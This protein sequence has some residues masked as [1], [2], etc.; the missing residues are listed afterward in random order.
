MGSRSPFTT[1]YVPS[2]EQ[3]TH[4]DAVRVATTA[5]VT[6]SGLQTLDGA[7]GAANDRV[8]V[9]NQTAAA[10]NGIYL[11]KSGAWARTEDFNE[12]TDVKDGVQV[13]VNEGSTQAN[14]EWALDTPG[15]IDVGTTALTFVKTSAAAL[16][17][18]GGGLTKTGDT[19][20]VVAGNG[21]QV[22]ADSVEVLY[23]VVNDHAYGDAAANGVATTLARSDHNHG[24]PSTIAGALAD[25]GLLKFK[26]VGKAFDSLIINA[27]GKLE[28]GSGDA[29]VDVN[30]FR[31]A[32]NVLATADAFRITG[33]SAGTVVLTLKAAAS[34]TANIVECQDSTG[35]VF[36]RIDSAGRSGVPFGSVVAPGL[37]F[38]NN[39]NTGLFRVGLDN[40]GVTVGGSKI[41][42]F[43]NNAG[44]LEYGLAGQAPTPRRT[45][46][47]TNVVTDRAY[48]ANATTL[49][50][51]ADVLGTLI[52]DL[53]EKGFV[54]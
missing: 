28:L 20:D 17:T 53:R 14:T 12:D 24:L 34:P 43:K 30:L 37:G 44:V 3:K 7:A 52:A 15:A 48:D 32:A 11:M 29:A 31:S 10:E 35:A 33:P 51:L 42:D 18:A 23:G 49:D 1:G 40:L 38:F 16:V 2:E 46:T 27:D 26:V 9:K 47:E 4:K 25:D 36:S 13:W 45:Y 8:L 41:A 50:E 19:L 6:R 21:V 22:N 5:N 54:A 39:A